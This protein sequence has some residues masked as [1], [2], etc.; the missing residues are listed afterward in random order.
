MD[1][2]SIGHEFRPRF[3][4]KAQ[5]LVWWT[6]MANDIVHKFTPVGSPWDV[7]G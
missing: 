2:T 3:D 1:S 6:Q 7:W 5:A 4:S